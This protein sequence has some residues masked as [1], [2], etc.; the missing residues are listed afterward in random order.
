MDFY[1]C[2]L[3]TKNI[4]RCLEN[5]MVSVMDTFKI[6]LTTYCLHNS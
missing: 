1:Y 5:T 6:T 2:V 3:E 4:T